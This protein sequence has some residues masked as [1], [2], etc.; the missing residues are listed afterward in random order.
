MPNEDMP[1]FDDMM[2][3]AQQEIESN[4]AEDKL[5]TR[6]AALMKINE[7]VE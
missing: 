3:E 4:D 2:N 5:D 7:Q 1:D 6:L